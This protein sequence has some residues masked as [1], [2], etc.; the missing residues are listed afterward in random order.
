MP[1]RT[2]LLTLLGTS[3]AVALVTP[4]ALDGSPLAIVAIVLLTV[5]VGILMGTTKVG[6]NLARFRP[7]AMLTESVAVYVPSTTDI[8]CTA[9][10]EL[11]AQ[12]VQQVTRTL[13]QLFGG[14]T[15]QAGTG[16]WISDSGALVQEPVQIVTSSASALTTQ[17][18]DSVMALARTVG[19]DMRQDCIAVSINGTLCLISPP[20][21]QP[22]AGTETGSPGSWKVADGFVH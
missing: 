1:P 12:T 20:A 4:L 14:A 9:D 22:Y 10:S 5:I 6:H 11:V 8:D 7:V 16:S 2:T 21:S 3:T 19:R 17:T 15:V 18:L 13:A